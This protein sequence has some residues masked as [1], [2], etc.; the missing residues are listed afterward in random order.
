ME[1]R[2]V[3]DALLRHHSSP[4]TCLLTPSTTL[5]W[6]ATKQLRCKSSHNHLSRRTFI[7]S[8]PL[9][10]TPPT[11][12]TTTSP[13]SVPTSEPDLQEETTSPPHDIN[14][15]ARDLGWVSPSNIRSA[16]TIA[17][18]RSAHSRHEALLN[19]GT[20]SDA[21]LAE[22]NRHN[23]SPQSPFDV[24]RMIDPPS[25]S[26]ALDAM[27]DISTNFTPPK[28]KR[29]PMRLEP[30]MGRSVSISG[31]GGVDLGRGLRLLE[32]SCARNRVRRDATS[33]RFHERAGLKRKRLRRERWRRRCLEGFKA[34]VGR[35]KTLKKQGW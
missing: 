35:V 34:T 30:A 1:L 25:G 13:P 14:Q 23:T 5:R 20:S 15:S 10:R 28:Q 31:G 27:K 18:S 29:I 24:S 4:L 11:P 26:K 6:Q 17:Y 33:Q 16:D 21:I 3:A 12:T 7:T 2:R 9:S 32:Q 19:G 22:I 8:T